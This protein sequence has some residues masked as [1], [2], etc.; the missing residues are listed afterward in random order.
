MTVSFHSLWKITIPSWTAISLTCLGDSTSL[1]MLSEGHAAVTKRSTQIRTDMHAHRESNSQ[2]II[3][4]FKLLLPSFYMHHG[5]PKTVLSLTKIVSCWIHFPFSF[6]LSCLCNCRFKAKQLEGHQTSDTFLN[7][8]NVCVHASG[9]WSQTG[10]GPRV[11]F[12]CLVA[13]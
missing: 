10:N 9:Y 1:I 5:S 4:I 8:N 13:S 12:I 6:F 2:C 3:K 11:P 7:I